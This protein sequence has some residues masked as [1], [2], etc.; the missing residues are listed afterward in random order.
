MIGGNYDD[1]RMKLN[2][3]EVAAGVEVVH[4]GGRDRVQLAS[5]I[6]VKAIDSFHV[7]VDTLALP[8]SPPDALDAFHPT[9]HVPERM[10][11]D[12]PVEPYPMGRMMSADVNSLSAWKMSSIIPEM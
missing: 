10:R 4:Q 5:E 8:G 7:A 9:N 3:F 2:P 1:P 6:I 11:Q 12:L